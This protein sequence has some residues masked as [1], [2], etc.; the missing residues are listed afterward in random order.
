[1]Q[2]ERTPKTQGRKVTTG[3]RNLTETQWALLDTIMAYR[4]PVAVFTKGGEGSAYELSRLDG[5][6]RT[7]V[8]D[9]LMGKKHDDITVYTIFGACLV[10]ATHEDGQRQIA[11]FAHPE[12]NPSI[13]G[14]AKL[15]ATQSTW[16]RMLTTSDFWITFL[17]G[18]VG[19]ALSIG[20]LFL[21][22][23]PGAME[24]PYFS[25]KVGLYTLILI[26][27]GL[28]IGMIFCVPVSY[29]M[30]K[31]RLL[32]AMRALGMQLP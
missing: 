24:I 18:I 16:W 30:Q 23:P 9:A 29:W 1:M 6:A 14:E 22:V 7:I 27:M 12:R 15:L 11:N 25:L 26:L 3:F 21:L 31:R 8:W 2:V 4:E 5:D 19:L 32:K 17:V 20:L 10:T 28:S 13:V